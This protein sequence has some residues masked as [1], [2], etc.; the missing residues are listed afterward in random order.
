MHCMNI[1][2][3]D[4]LFCSNCGNSQQIN[5]AGHLLLPGTF[6]NNRYVVGKCLGEG[7]FGITYIGRD[8][9]LDRLVAIK[10]Y[11]PAG[12]VNRSNTVSA[13]VVLNTQGNEYF[14]QGCDKF[15]REARILAKFSDEPGIV[16]VIDFFK[17]NDTAYIIMDYLKGITLQ[18]Y[19]KQKG[20]LS[21][22]EAL[23]IMLPIMISLEKIHKQGLIH[24]DI[25]PSNI[26]II[27]DKV[28][29]IDFGAARN[30]S[31]DGNNSLS[32]MLKPGYAPEEQYR[33]KGLQGPWTDAYAICATIYRCITGVVPDEANNRIYCDEIKTPSALGINV[34]A[35]FEHA[36]MKGLS[37]YYNDRYHSINELLNGFKGIEPVISDD[38]PTTVPSSTEDAVS[39]EYRSAG[40]EDNK[41]TEYRSDNNSELNKEQ[42]SV[43]SSSESSTKPVEV[44]V[45]APTETKN[46]K[47]NRA[48]LI[49]SA[50]VVVILLIVGVIILANV[51]NNNIVAEPS[52]NESLTSMSTSSFADISSDNSSKTELE[53]SVEESS[54][55]SNTSEEESSDNIS[56]VSKP[57]KL[58][59]NIYDYK[60]MIGSDIYNLPMKYSEF[61]DN[62]WK[63]EKSFDED[64]V[65]EAGKGYEKNFYQGNYCI[66]VGFY[67][68]S[69]NNRIVSD[70]YAVSF[71]I[72]GGAKI[73][74]QRNSYNQEGTVFMLPK[75]ICLGE[76]SLEDI[77]AAYGDPAG[78]DSN[79]E[80][81]YLTYTTKV[82]YNDYYIKL[83]V[84]N[85]TNLLNNISMKNLTI[86]EDFVDDYTPT[87]V[88]EEA[89]NYTA[90]KELG[91]DI[92]SGVFSFY[93]DLY[94]FPVPLDAFIKNGWTIK[95]SSQ[96]F[97]PA[98]SSIGVTITRNDVYENLTVYNYESDSVQ[99][100]YGLVERISSY[101]TSP[102]NFLSSEEIVENSDKI[103]KMIEED[104][105]TIILPN[106]I[107]LT[108]SDFEI[109]EK[110][111]NI[112]FECD[113]S[114]GK[115]YYIPIEKYTEEEMNSMTYF[116]TLLPEKCKDFKKYIKIFVDT[117]Y[118][119]VVEIEINMERK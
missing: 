80:Y 43:K 59:D 30:V 104:K 102:A 39:T 108:I 56:E 9:N 2:G 87:K 79:S 105:N 65:L 85:E 52:K 46:K 26:M 18:E 47:K 78:T 115:I 74:G 28:K 117:E 14:N 77:K 110:L 44:T 70:C 109:T 34:D 50:S 20:K 75:N 31:V 41:S 90:P 62:G 4:D 94:K 15:L 58:G 23:R 12:Y 11:Y 21:A 82:E 68:Y 5:I 119:C 113:D 83:T 36:L 35:T 54:V 92:T 51:K 22:D 112:E 118:D 13:N 55:I 106:D 114:I 1:I 111:K 73:F 100:K 84:N 101:Y 29:L 33:S 25:S 32:L 19:I 86:P 69:K 89:K 116:S 3:E 103:S 99:L 61:I 24:R 27:N 64:T 7:G 98:D 45:P 17:Q 49:I 67:N 72:Y 57:S 88:P 53:S 8:I 63:P 6:L 48:P 96:D 71:D 37:V 40:T 93:G 16:G 66:I 95:E 38:K 76:S 97:I 10:E 91:T 60:I 42:S 81:T 107:C